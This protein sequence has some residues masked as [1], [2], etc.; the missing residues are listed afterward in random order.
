MGTIFINIFEI[1][2]H[3]HGSCKLIFLCRFYIRHK[4]FYGFLP[5]LKIDSISIEFQAEPI[6]KSAATPFSPL[7]NYKTVKKNNFSCE[8][9]FT[10]S[11]GLNARSN[12]RCIKFS[13]YIYLLNPDKAWFTPSSVMC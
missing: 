6:R 11:V 3:S 7:A 12:P 2:T 9:G 4:R 1:E 5:Y 8:I 10:C 13:N